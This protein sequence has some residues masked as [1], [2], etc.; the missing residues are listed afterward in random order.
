[1]RIVLLGDI[2]VHQLLPAPWHWFSKRI[3]GQTNLL[4]NRRSRFDLARLPDVFAHALALKPD[5]ILHTGDWTTTALPAEFDRA[6]RLI[7]AIP[8]HIPFI[9]IPGNHDRYTFTAARTRRFEQYFGPFAPKFYPHHRDL[10]EGIHLIALDATY[11]TLMHAHGRC[12]EAQLAASRESLT[13]LKDVRR[14]I[15]MNHYPLVTPPP[16]PPEVKPE[17]YFHRLRDADALCGIL[18]SFGRPVLYLH[19]HVH[20]PW[21]FTLPGTQITDLNAGAPVMR[22]DDYPAGQGF[23]QIDIDPDAEPPRFKLHPIE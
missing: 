4:L 7:G 5:F 14:L 16:P 15:V 8:P 6:R 3:L 21:C 18:Q 9:T 11:P 13:A 20:Q 2:H 22:S 19:G 1:M 12:G 17:S 10:G 23:W